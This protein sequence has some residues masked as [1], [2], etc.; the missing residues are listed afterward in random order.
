MRLSLL[1]SGSNGN[2]C[3]VEDGETRLLIDAGIGPRVLARRLEPL[4]LAPSDLTH[5]VL[6]H[7]HHDHV[8]GLAGLIKR[9]PEL[10]IYVSSAACEHLPAEARRRARRFHPGESFAIGPLTVTPHGAAH[11][12]PGAVCL[13]LEGHGAR[14]GYATDLGGY[15]HGTVELLSGLD[16]LVVEANHCPTMLRVGP[17]PAYLK[18]RVAGPRGHLSNQ[19]CHRLLDEVMHPGLRHVLLAHLSA[20]NNAPQAVWAELDELVRGAP[21]GTFSLGSRQEAL[22]RVEVVPGARATARGQLALPI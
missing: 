4:G 7:A 18:R 12:A 2:C 22:P 10:A 16:A 15:S 6:T 8:A 20:V 5:C 21:R 3:L 17:Y 19:Q 11:D 13:R 1:A 9:Q 14:L